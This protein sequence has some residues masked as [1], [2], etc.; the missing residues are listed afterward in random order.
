MSVFT[1]KQMRDYDPM[2]V[3]VIRMLVAALV[4]LPVAMWLT[5][6]DV[7]QVNINGWW[8]LLYAAIPG[9]FFAFILDFRNTARFGATVAVMVTY[10]IPVVAVVSGT[11]LLGEQITSGMLAGTLLIVVG[12]WLI[13]RKRTTSKGE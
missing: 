6:L 8:V 12:I 2:D 11:L 13:L 9:T 7:S 3:N 1:R 4:L 5:G 10:V